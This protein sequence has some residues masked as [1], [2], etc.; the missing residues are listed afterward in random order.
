MVV[1]RDE[2]AARIRYSRYKFGSSQNAMLIVSDVKHGRCT[3]DSE[4]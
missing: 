4:M 3:A 2:S 1:L